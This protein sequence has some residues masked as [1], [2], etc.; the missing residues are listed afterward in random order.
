MIHENEKTGLANSD[1]AK[2]FLRYQCRTNHPLRALER[3]GLL[4]P[5]RLNARALRYRWSDLHKLVEVSQ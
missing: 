2:K 5:V 4:T 1:E 3:K